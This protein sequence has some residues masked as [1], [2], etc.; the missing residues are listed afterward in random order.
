VLPLHPG[1]DLADKSGGMEPKD[2]LFK[3]AF[4]GDQEYEV[5]KRIRFRLDNLAV[6]L[7]SPDLKH[8][9]TLLISITSTYLQSS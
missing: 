1:S 6:L 2:A 7:W 5:R 8:D 9:E 3:V 4:D